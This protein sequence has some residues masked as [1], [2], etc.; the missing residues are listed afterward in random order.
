MDSKQWAQELPP[1]VREVLEAGATMSAP[2]DA[3]QAVWSALASKLPAATVGAATGG[4]SALTILKPLALGLLVGAV[5]TAGVLEIRSAIAPAPRPFAST[6]RARV[7]PAP[8][9]SRPSELEPKAPEQRPTGTNSNEPAL[10]GTGTL[11]SAQSTLPSTA[12]STLLGEAPPSSEKPAT[13]AFPDQAPG[14]PR[15]DATL[16]ESR[17]LNQA[18][19]A[20]QAGDA[21]RALAQLDAI[22]ADFPQGVLVQERDALRIEA[23]L[24]LGERQRARE[25]ARR[26]LELHPH[27]PHAAAV[28]RALR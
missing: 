4:L 20:L 1:E 6:S 24:E 5:A 19:T 25:L 13:A 16:L 14:T 8:I 7:P 15:A 21:R 27:S 11:G 9:Q 10:E 12:P 2:S 17:R 22:A 26:F 3:K 18:R 23:L 28:D